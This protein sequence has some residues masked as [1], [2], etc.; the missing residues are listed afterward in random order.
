MWRFPL[1]WIIFNYFSTDL[2]FFLHQ[3]VQYGPQGSKAWSLGWFVFPAS[4]HD[5][6]PVF[7]RGSSTTSLISYWKLQTTER[8]LRYLHNR[9]GKYPLFFIWVGNIIFRFSYYLFVSTHIKTVGRPV[10][11]NWLTVYLLVIGS[12]TPIEVLLLALNFY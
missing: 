12:V 1:R 7:K 3:I 4:T 2:I 5:F 10:C 9:A 11:E 6:V 8:F